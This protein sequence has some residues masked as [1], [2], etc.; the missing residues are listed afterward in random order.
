MKVCKHLKL[1]KNPASTLPGVRSL[2][3]L[4]FFL[5]VSSFPAQAASLQEITTPKTF[6]DWCLNKAN[7]SVE[8]KRT[9]DAL[10]EEA[11]TQDCHQANKLL[12]RSTSLNLFY[13]S[14]SD[15]RPLSTLTNLR[16]LD[17]REPDLE[18]NEVTDLRPLSKLTNL[19]KLYLENNRITDLRPLLTLT[20]L[21]FLY[22]EN[23]RITDLRPLSTLTKLNSLELEN[24]EITDLRPLSTLTNL[25]V[26]YLRNNQTLVDKTCPVK[27]ESI[28]TF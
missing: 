7:L 20:N 24:N 3:T 13:K 19:K 14:I 15:L 6:A 28:C 4:A 18:N 16:E 8:T 17:L 1:N 26:L 27:P 10:L 9:I 5:F 23:N 11:K 12:S 22:L 25:A 2:G 21:N